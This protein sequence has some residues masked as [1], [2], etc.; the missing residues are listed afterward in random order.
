MLVAASVVIAASIVLTGCSLAGDEIPQPTT[1]E[2]DAMLTQVNDI[3]WQNLQFAPDSPR[4]TVE[5]ERFI[6]PSEADAVYTACMAESG[7]DGW[8]QANYNALGGPPEAERLDVYA[9]I[10]RFP[11][12]PVYYGLRTSSQLDAVYDYYRDSLLPC[13]R[14]AGMDVTETPTRE[15][16]VASTSFGGQWNPHWYA[17]PRAVGAD[18]AAYARC[19]DL[20][21]V[22]GSP[23]EGIGPAAP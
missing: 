16:F 13:L 8:Q 21:Y 4:P 2:L 22:I 3:Q 5:F 20:S 1:A 7:Y 17:F 6:E 15:E 9:C 10:A 12:P 18:L 23:I 14:A 11:I 19:G